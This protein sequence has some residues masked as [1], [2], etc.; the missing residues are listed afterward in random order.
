[1]KQLLLLA[2]LIISFSSFQAQEKETIEVG[3]I[4]NLEKPSG[5]DFNYIHFPKPN[6]IIKQGGIVNYNREFNQ[7]VEIIAIKTKK[8]G[9]R[10]VRLKRTDGRK[11]FQSHRSIVANIDKAIKAGEISL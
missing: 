4:V 5:P 6:F 2:I 3:T 11:F 7:P 8:D 10:Q 9:T 1:M